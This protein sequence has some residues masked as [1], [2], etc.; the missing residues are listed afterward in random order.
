MNRR[1]RPASTLCTLARRRRSGDGPLPDRPARPGAGPVRLRARTRS[2]RRAASSAAPTHCAVHRADDC[3]AR[4][5]RVGS[6]WPAVHVQ[7][8]KKT[9]QRWPGRSRGSSSEAG[10]AGARQ[11]P[12]AIVDGSQMHARRARSVVAN[13]GEFTFPMRWRPGAAAHHKKVKVYPHE[14]FADCSGPGRCPAVHRFG[15]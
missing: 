1:R 9:A 5:R 11:P 7:A 4:V 2:A 3:R 15:R 10:R 14:E 12:V 6:R 8:W 13:N